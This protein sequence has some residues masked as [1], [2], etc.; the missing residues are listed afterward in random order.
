MYK[1]SGAREKTYVIKQIKV[2]EKQES[3]SGMFILSYAN[4][5]TASIQCIIFILKKR[6]GNGQWL[7]ITC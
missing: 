7:I 3:T 2:I 1:V 6:N 5:F 4:R